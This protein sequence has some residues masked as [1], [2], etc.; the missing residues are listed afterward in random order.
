MISK[1]DIIMAYRLILGREPENEAVIERHLERHV[2]KGLSVAELGEFFLNSSE[3]RGRQQFLI[4][5]ELAGQ[6]LHVIRS[7]CMGEIA[8]WKFRRIRYE[9]ALEE[10]QRLK[11]TVGWLFLFKIEGCRVSIMNKPAFLNKEGFELVQRRAEA[12]RDF[13]EYVVRTRCPNI[14]TIMAMNVGDADDVCNENA[15]IFVFQK[16]LGSRSLL[17]P[18][19]DFLAWRF[20]NSDDLT[21]T[22][23]YTQKTNSAV[24]AGSTTGAPSI[25]A[26]SVRQLALPRLRSAMFFRDKPLVDFRLPKIVRATAEAEKLLRDMGFGSGPL[27]WSQQFKH[28]FIISTD[29]HG[30]TCSRVVIGLKSNSVLLKYN[31]PHQLYYFKYLRPWIHYIPIASDPDIVKTIEMETRDPGFFDFI[32]QEGKQFA[33]QYLTRQ[34]VVNYAACLLEMYVDSFWDKSKST[35]FSK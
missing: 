13:L 29:G 22:V 9:Q 32:A 28:K 16:P 31:S 18:D 25:D 2:G 3:L 20:Y 17:F 6:T 19:I 33:E 26:D 7:W 12:Y 34:Q 30:A 23:P 24:F 27:A 1:S 4:P 15:P 5:H 35:A 10:Y 8:A 21:D 11:A 14:E